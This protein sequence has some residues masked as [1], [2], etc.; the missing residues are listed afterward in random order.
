MSVNLSFAQFGVKGKLA[1]ADRAY[2]S[3]KYDKAIRLYIK[4]L[5]KASIRSAY[6][7]IAECYRL[8]DNWTEAE[9]WYG[10]VV[11]YPDGKHI[12][13]L[14]YA[15]ALQKNGKCDLAMEWFSEYLRHVPDDE[16][17]INA[18]Q[19]CLPDNSIILNWRISSGIV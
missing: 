4:V 2:S 6:E 13:E 1:R 14:Y 19:K 10:Q 5:D 12:F 3:K 11:N 8:T 16:E 7:N 17:A 15:I 18:K 9:Y